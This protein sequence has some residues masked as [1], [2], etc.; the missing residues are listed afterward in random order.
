M[1]IHENLTTLLLVGEEIES[2][3]PSKELPIKNFVM[4]GLPLFNDIESPI[5]NLAIAIL[6]YKLSA[7]S[8][9][10]NSLFDMCIFLAKI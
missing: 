5:G 6:A 10:A 4:A 1:S 8:V 2:I 7:T 3:G 9:N